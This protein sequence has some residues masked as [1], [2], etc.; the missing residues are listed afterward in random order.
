MRPYSEAAQTGAAGIF[1]V[2]THGLGNDFVLVDGREKVFRPQAPLIEQI[3]DRHRGIGGD[4]LLVLEVPQNARA[5]VRMRIYNVD[6]VEAQTCFNAT[7]CAAFLWMQEAGK[8]S[9]VLE[10]LGGLIEARMAEAENGQLRVSLH[11]APAVTDWQ[12][13]PL[14]G[15]L[16]SHDGRLNHGPLSE[17]FAVNMGNP[18]LVYFV[19]DFDAVDVPLYADVLQNSSYLPEQANIGVAELLPNDGDEAQLKLV[20]YERPGILTQACGSGACAAAVAT[21]RSGRTNQKNFRVFMPGGALQVELC[22]DDT[23]ILTG[24]VAVAFYGFWPPENTYGT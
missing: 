15:P 11:L 23:I 13:I 18:H 9:V 6:G 16:A 24:D 22:A 10:T 7:R 21:L 17:P 3:C 4:Q 8:T 1:F 5:D 12:A 20:V 14:A 2:K 19:P